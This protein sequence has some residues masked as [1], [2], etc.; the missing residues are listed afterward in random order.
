VAKRKNE[1]D[2]D[3]IYNL[4][5]PSA[6]K[7][8]PTAPPPEQPSAPPAMPV[9]QPAPPIPAAPEPRPAM[10]DAATVITAAPE[11]QAPSVQPEPETPGPD[12]ISALKERLFSS[13]G[14]IDL[15]MRTRRE[16]ALVNLVELMVTER[17]DDAFEKFS[18]CRCDKCRKDVA[19]IAL[20]LLPPN[21]VVTEPEK[22]PELMSQG[23]SQAISAALVKAILQVRGNPRH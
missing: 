14:T 2:K 18:C 16:Y 17:L 1:L 13:K 10:S 22:V 20:N 8:N 23:A 5:M 12:A 9:Q 7:S 11:L 15:T 6:A 3:Y 21:Y 19:A 4:I